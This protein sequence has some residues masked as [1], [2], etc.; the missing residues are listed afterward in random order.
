MANVDVR[1]ARARQIRV[2]LDRARLE[3]LGISAGEVTRALEAESTVA[4]GGDVRV[5]SQR[6]IVRTVGRFASLEHIAQ[7]VV[8]TRRGVPVRVMDIATVRDTV[9]D[10]TSITRLNGRPSIVIV[11]S[12]RFG[13]NTVAVARCISR[14]AASP[15]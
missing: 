15:D 8:T 12:K 5:D 6:R 10:A 3:A 1:G 14:V 2:E 11:I 4:P 13:T 9:E 7:T